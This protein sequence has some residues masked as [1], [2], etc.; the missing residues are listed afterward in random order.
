MLKKR[1][2]KQVSPPC[3]ADGLLLHADIPFLC[4]RGRIPAPPA[5]FYI[6][7]IPRLIGCLWNE[8]VRT[9][10]VIPASLRL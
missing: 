8:P 10:P 6:T 7:R 1:Q 4:K 2:D 9:L 3:P 5:P